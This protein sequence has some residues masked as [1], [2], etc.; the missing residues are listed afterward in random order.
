MFSQYVPTGLMDRP[1]RRPN[2]GIVVRLNIFS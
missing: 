2:L 1:D